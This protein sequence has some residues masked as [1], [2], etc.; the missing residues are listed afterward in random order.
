MRNE[1]HLAV[2]CSVELLPEYDADYFHFG[3]TL[4]VGICPGN[5]EN[6][7]IA[8]SE[9]DPELLKP[10]KWNLIKAVSIRVIE[11][12]DTCKPPGGSPCADC[13]PPARADDK[14]FRNHLCDRLEERFL[15]L[16]G[17][18]LINC[19]WNPESNYRSTLARQWST[20]LARASALPYPCAQLANLSMA[21]RIA[22]DRFP[23]GWKWLI[24]APTFSLSA[25]D[26]G[27][28]ASYQPDLA[29]G[30]DPL[31]NGPGAYT[32][33]YEGVCPIPAIAYVK[34]A[35]SVY[36]AQCEKL[37]DP[38]TLWIGPTSDLTAIFGRDWRAF[39]GR[40]VAE[41]FDLAGALVQAGQD[42]AALPSESAERTRLQE[43]VIEYRRLVLGTLRDT[44]N[45]G[46]RAGP[47][48]IQLL[49]RVWSAVHPSGRQAEDELHSTLSYQVLTCE[50]AETRFWTNLI[51]VPAGELPNGQGSRDPLLRWIQFLKKS[52]GSLGGLRCLTDPL[53]YQ[54]LGDAIKEL[55]VIRNR[56]RGDAGLVAFA[57]G[58]WKQALVRTGPDGLPEASEDGLP[59]PAIESF[60]RN[61]P[62]V[63]LGVDAYQVLAAGLL[64]TPGSGG[65]TSNGTPTPAWDGIVSAIDEASVKGDPGRESEAAANAYFEAFL[66][67]GSARIEDAGDTA[68][69]LPPI[70]LSARQGEQ[71]RELLIPYLQ[72]FAGT[73]VE[74]ICEQP[75][76]A[77]A[78][79]RPTR[80]PHAL[81]MQV[82]AL[83]A[84]GAPGNQRD[85]D[86]W[87]RQIS[88]VGVLMRRKDSDQ[89]WHCLNIAAL[90]DSDVLRSD[91]WAPG[92][93]LV[94]QRLPYQDGL[95]QP[96]VSYDNTPL[97]ARGPMADLLDHQLMPATGNGYLEPGGLISYTYYKGKEEGPGA[98][99]AWSRIPGLV[100]GK[101]YE[102]Q[103]FAISNS[104]ALPKE[105][106]HYETHPAE[107][108]ETEPT[109]D[110]LRTQT[111]PYRRRVPVGG[112]RLCHLP[113]V[114]SQ[115]KDW[116]PSAW[117]L[118][119]G[120]EPRHD[121]FPSVPP[122]CFPRILE[123]F[124]GESDVPGDAS[125]GERATPPLLLLRP[126]KLE[127]PF[128]DGTGIGWSSRF[129]VLQPATDIQTWDRWNALDPGTQPLRCSVWA[130]YARSLCENHDAVRTEKIGVLRD[131]D[132]PDPASSRFHLELIE[133]GPTGNTI[134]KFCCELEF[135]RCG[136][137]G[138][139]GLDSIRCSRSEIQVEVGGHS[140]IAPSIEPSKVTI[141][142]RKGGLYRLIISNVLSK[143]ARTRFDNIV[144]WEQLKLGDEYAVSPQQVFIEVATDE[145]PDPGCL[146][147]APTPSFHCSTRTLSVTAT[148]EAKTAWTIRNIDLLRQV[149]QWSGRL[150]AEPPWP[151][152]I[153]EEWMQGW[154]D[155]I[156]DG[157]GGISR[158]LQRVF[159][160]EVQQFGHRPDSDYVRI[161]MRPNLSCPEHSEFTFEEQLA[162][163]PRSSYYR[164]QFVAI[165]RYAGLFRDGWSI[166][167]SWTFNDG[168]EDKARYWRAYIT[169]CSV[170]E[171]PPR[172]VLRIAVP[173]TRSEDELNPQP[174]ILVML[175]EPWF[176]KAGLVETLEAEVVR[177]H[178]GPSS[179]TISRDEIGPDPIIARIKD[180]L[181]DWVRVSYE[182][183]DVVGPIGHTF[184]SASGARY[185][186]A[187]SFILRIPAEL[188]LVGSL[189]SPRPDDPGLT[190]NLGWFFVR[191]RFRRRLRG[192]GFYWS[193]FCKDG[194]EPTDEDFTE[195][196]WIQLLPAF[197][198]TDENVSPG[199]RTLQVLEGGTRVQLSVEDTPVVEAVAPVDP[200]F[201]RFVLLTR[202]VHDA[203][204]G[205]ADQEAYAGVFRWCGET[206]MWELLPAEGRE[207]IGKDVTARARIIE[208]QAGTR[209]GE[210]VVGTESELWGRLFPLDGSED[211]ER[212]TPFRLGD[213]GS[214]VRERERAR[215]VRMSRPFQTPERS[216]AKQAVQTRKRRQHAGR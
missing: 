81:T 170:P 17:E 98:A 56:L 143:A 21:F 202:L 59:E 44:A 213:H 119:P 53:A 161:P 32:W 149:W 30:C 78:E 188:D 11:A 22:K 136:S 168:D 123:L 114:G 184:D 6:E 70:G 118:Q 128:A 150:V 155:R 87:L 47:S 79:H 121:F 66:R 57:V 160:W 125:I 2:V 12:D 75:I 23:Q 166:S 204:T 89:I 195:G 38:A 42:I 152:D 74:R 94:P 203:A 154:L 50:E 206:G 63:D 177:A 169:P 14:P 34:P 116:E 46:W 180:A 186:G 1:A 117:V 124:R 127:V 183:C 69:L 162:Q 171:P 113:M 52:D 18:D 72:T 86:D 191:L 210:L 157:M 131:T 7:A 145:L 164:F 176:Q 45:L 214:A 165:S 175:R 101:D 130:D 144:E 216:K 200:Q 109:G 40:I 41:G 27:L 179:A 139:G 181:P 190:H 76:G 48:G 93:F 158:K 135:G 104:G 111:V 80:T 174:G 84:A 33:E 141:T 107:L 205:R 115:E 92:P 20:F 212:L 211:L 58:Q 187:T 96:F 153:G 105:L 178:T 60:L 156:V 146:F 64:S 88:G 103:A 65:S 110:L 151:A 142:V 133:Y 83:C 37:V 106:A 167:A 134:D 61:V 73:V 62:A 182:N 102:I 201:H 215:I 71:L 173:L 147:L 185:F 85:Q 172:P 25:E 82:G 68:G 5:D 199:K 100:F 163:D 8:R 95:R 122:G 197:D 91:R 112:P 138:N 39:L 51:D 140:E 207:P 126:E 35:S 16:S 10:W 36:S 129:G 193:G 49:D 159:T 137:E 26:A 97:V 19:I 3:L 120:D 15:A 13:L 31:P 148:L 196:Q 54:D 28:E 4:S 108:R 9:L 67:Y 132:V 208:V 90:A 77:S 55:L 189:T 29:G 99:Q 43:L 194:P 24:A 192:P 209:E 198:F